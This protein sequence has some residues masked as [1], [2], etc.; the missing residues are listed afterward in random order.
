M[1]HVY[2]QM[3]MLVMHSGFSFTELYSFPVNLRD[4]SF[5]RLV[6]H[7]EEQKKSE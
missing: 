1:N 7:F 5:K 6:K 4:W 2:E 3:F